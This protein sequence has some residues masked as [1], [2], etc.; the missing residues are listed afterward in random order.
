MPS[1][2]LPATSLHYLH[3]GSGSPPIVFVHGAQCSHADW[4]HQLSH[5]AA[6]HAVVAPDL[7][8]HGRSAKAPGRLDIGS[9]AADVLALCDALGLGR[10]VLVGHS[11]GCRVLLQACR[12]APGRIAALVCIDGAYLAPGLH[13][14]RSDAEREALAA[15]MRERVAERL[16]GDG[17]QQ[18]LRR[19]FGQMFFDP[20]FDAERDALIE[21]ALALPP[22]VARELMPSFAAWDVAHLERALATVKVPMLVVGCTYMDSDQQRVPLAAGASTPWL[23]AVRLHAPHAEI[24]HY[25]G[26]GHFPML[27]RPEALNADVEAFLG[28]HGLG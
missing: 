3:E 25:E 8:G 13:G 11:M 6:S 12:S 5:F 16:F 10:V 24:L 15:Q 23:D 7:H 14:D 9:L 26:S 19:G 2:D 17:Q 18:R 1:I 27:E 20:R 4:R 22:H 28:R 21:Q